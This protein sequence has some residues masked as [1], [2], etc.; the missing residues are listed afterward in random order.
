MIYMT[1]EMASCYLRDFFK[2][3]H[4]AVE[5]EADDGDCSGVYYGVYPLLLLLGGLGLAKGIYVNVKS[6]FTMKKVA[7]LELGLVEGAQLALFGIAAFYAMM[8]FALRSE[9]TIGKTEIGAFLWFCVVVATAVLMNWCKSGNELGAG[10]EED[11]SGGQ[12]RATLN[13]LPSTDERRGNKWQNLWSGG[14]KGISGSGALRAPSQRGIAKERALAAEA[15][16]TG[17]GSAE[18]E[19]IDLA[20]GYC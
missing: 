2:A 14:A 6:G 11:G 16:N 4:G 20:P 3:Q 12:P 18:D 1:S 13:R 10:A 7:T 17:G 5:L 8:A 9:R 19:G 15:A